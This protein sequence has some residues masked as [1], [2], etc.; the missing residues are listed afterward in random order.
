MPRPMRRA[1]S[2]GVPSRSP[3]RL[4]GFAGRH[5]VE[6]NC[7]FRKLGSL[8]LGQSHRTDC[9]VRAYIRA[10]CALDAVVSCPYGN[11]D[12]DTALLKCSSAGR[13]GA[14]IV[15]GNNRYRNLVTFLTV[16][17]GLDVVDEV[18]DV[19]TV[20]GSDSD[21]I[22]FAFALAPAVGNINLDDVLGTCVDSGAVLVDNVL[23]LA[24]VGLLG[25]SIHELDRL[26]LRD[27]VGEFEECGLKDGVDP[28]RAHAGL[29]TDLDTVDGVELD[30][31]VMDEALD[32]RRK[33][34][35]KAFRCAPAAVQKERA[36][37]D[38]LLGHVELADVCR[39]VA[40]NEVRLAYQIGGLR[41]S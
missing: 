36:A 32:L 24:A 13:S 40:C 31:V 30:V 12:C 28:G 25:S 16:D 20:A 22:L 39:V 9:S 15:C 10:E 11:V 3:T 33:V 6:S 21:V 8:F 2:P 17:L 37:V 38:Q 5:E 41:L 14:F 7:A 27:D 26:F 35:L 18:N 19:L 23:T 4:P 34:G 1:R 29:D